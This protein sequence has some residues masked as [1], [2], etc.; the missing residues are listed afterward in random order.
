[1]SSDGSPRSRSPKGEKAKGD[2]PNASPPVVAVANDDPDSWTE[3]IWDA[4][5]PKMDKKND[6]FKDDVKQIVNTLVGKQIERL[7]KDWTQPA[8]N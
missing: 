7:E 1:M 6:D 4:I 8:N 3:Q 2:L 5:G